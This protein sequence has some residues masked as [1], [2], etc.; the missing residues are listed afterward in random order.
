MAA[1]TRMAYALLFS[2]SRTL[3]PSPSPMKPSLPLVNP[4][5]LSLERT[6]SCPQG[7]L[8]DAHKFFQ[9]SVFTALFIFSLKHSSRL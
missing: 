3:M 8:H 9:L 7:G 4:N 5:I 2:L 1:P 6:S